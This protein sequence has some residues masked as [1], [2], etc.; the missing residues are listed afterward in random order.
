MPP[1]EA[2]RITTSGRPSPNAFRYD[3]PVPRTVVPLD[4]S[5]LAALAGPSDRGRLADLLGAEVVAAGR[6]TGG[7]SQAGRFLLRL[8]D[9]RTL[10]LKQATDDRSAGWLRDEAR[11]YAALREDFLPQVLAFIDDGRRPLLLLED[12]SFAHWPPPF[13]DEQVRRLRET[14]GRLARV[15]V[16]Q[17]VPALPGVWA[18]TPGWREVAVDPG[19]LLGLGLCDAAWLAAALPVLLAAADPA[20]LAGD[21]L[22]H[23]DVR[24]DNLCFLPARTVLVDWNWACRGAAE[25]ELALLAPSLHADGGPPPEALLPDAKGLAALV[26][27]LLA[28]RAGLPP[29]TV[30]PGVRQE[31]RRQLAVALP[32]AARAL[33][34]PPPGAG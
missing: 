25:M 34:L 28:A 2:F 3:V 14:L 13:S 15:P 10:F 21:S 24:G 4:P 17:G 19:P 26:C 16:P 22:L 29:D 5:E 23:M 20:L 12:L 11:I 1:P 32:W 33:R 31:Q 8:G 7:F 9:D 6:V 27:G 30:P 18:R